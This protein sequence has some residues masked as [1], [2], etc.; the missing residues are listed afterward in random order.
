MRKERPPPRVVSKQVCQ[1]FSAF[2][3]SFFPP[4][5][6]VDNPIL[7]SERIRNSDKQTPKDYKSPF[8]NDFVSTWLLKIM[9]RRSFLASARYLDPFCL[10]YILPPS[11]VHKY[12]ELSLLYFSAPRTHTYYT[13]ERTQEAKKQEH[14]KEEKRVGT[15]E[16]M[17]RD[18]RYWGRQS[19]PHTQQQ[20]SGVKRF[21]LGPWM[22]KTLLLCFCL[23]WAKMKPYDTRN[24]SSSANHL[25]ILSSREIFVHRPTYI[26]VSAKLFS[27]LIYGVSVD[28][29][30]HVVQEICQL[31]AL[32]MRK[33]SV[34]TI[35]NNT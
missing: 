31:G 29:E 12:D 16:K 17:E 23:P 11:L 28:P 21:F 14:G 26:F 7:Q 35:Q 34:E 18:V 20:A 4:L 3:P 32:K 27:P 24:S 19:G 2:L 13:Y 8:A 30:N 10:H 9:H 33:I 1:S 25:T 6:F 5:P 22:D 15:W